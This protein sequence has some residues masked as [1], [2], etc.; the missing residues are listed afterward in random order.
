M[1]TESFNYV[2]TIF[3]LNL[4][5]IIDSYLELPSATKLL[6]IPTDD[7]DNSDYEEFCNNNFRDF[8][9]ILNYNGLS[10][11]IATHEDAS[12]RDYYYY[13]FRKIDRFIINIWFYHQLFFP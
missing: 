1:N 8:I 3:G 13:Q 11:V 6:D 10:K 5:K 2:K 4:T 7:D 9:A 12:H